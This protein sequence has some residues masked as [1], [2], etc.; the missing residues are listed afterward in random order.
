M[1]M[2]CAHAKRPARAALVLA[3]TAVTANAQLTFVDRAEETG[4]T[5]LSFGRGSAMIDL[6][7]DGQLD[8]IAGNTDSRNEFFHQ[9]P[10]HTFENVNVEWGIAPLE[11]TTFGV[12]ATDFDNDGDAD[13]YFINGGFLDF[14]ANRLLRNDLN[15][16]GV[17]TNVSGASGAAGGVARTFGGTA[18]DYDRDGDVDIFLTV[19]EAGPCMLLRND[20]N[21]FF[22]DVSVSAGL[23]QTGAFR[24]CSSG[25]FNNDGWIDV[26]VGHFD[27][28]NL[29][30]RNNG[31][32]TFTDVAASAGVQ[33]P[34]KNFGLVL[35]DF[36]ND[37]WMDIYAPKWQKIATMNSPLF[38]NDGDGTF[39]DVT[40]GSGMTGQ[41]DMGHNTGDLDGDGYPDIYIG[42]GAPDFPADDILFLITPDG[43]GGLV[44]TDVSH[45]S[46]IT[47]NGPTRCHGMPFGD[48]DKNGFIDIYANNGG[49]GDL[50]ETMEENFLW[51][52]QGNDNGWTALRLTGVASNRS[53]VGTRSV[54]VTSSGREIHRYL[55]V[56]SGFANTDSPIQHYGIGLDGEIEHIEIRW[57]SGN[58]QFVPHPP[59]SRI[60]DVTECVLPAYLNP[61]DADDDGDVDLL[62]YG[63][64]QTCFPAAGGPPDPRC[65][66]FDFSTDC[67]IDL[68]DVPGFLD[69]ST[70]PVS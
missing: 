68:A 10:D 60:T 8:I 25:D 30:Y 36:D 3:V 2:A 13:V 26:A 34:P 70:D 45:S 11:R 28:P 47:S 40:A 35:E 44:A 59:L 27:A 19:N 16:S 17:F 64:L 9:L 56:G 58:R 42:T 49:M 39:T 14:Q 1:I 12:L 67:N 24:H 43:S 54:A 6:D 21:L 22:T 18:L 4:T 50:P 52:N 48:Y 23:F 55:D 51:Q 31:D 33:S 66:V 29:L 57:P 46:G 69:A 32:G 41:T 61:G 65:A 53:A 15:V 20:G 38:H 63:V 37:G 7:G 62:D 5:N